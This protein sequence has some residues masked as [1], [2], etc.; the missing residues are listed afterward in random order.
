MLNEPAR[1]GGKSGS[2]GRKPGDQS[3]VNPE[4]ALAGDRARTKRVDA[5][6]SVAPAGLENHFI[7]YP[8]LTPGAT[9][10]YAR[11]RGLV[12]C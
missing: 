6:I 8:G 3:H 4:P 5:F 1:A 11:S 7:I 10:L 2:P 12:D 9:T